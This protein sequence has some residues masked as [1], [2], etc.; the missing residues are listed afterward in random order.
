MDYKKIDTSD[1]KKID[2]SLTAW[3]ENGKPGSDALSLGVDLVEYVHGLAGRLG[4]ETDNGR[5]KLVE[6]FISAPPERAKLQSL[7]KI[8]SMPGHPLESAFDQLQGLIAAVRAVQAIRAAMRDEA[9]IHNHAI[10]A[11]EH[12]AK[13]LPILRDKPAVPPPPIELVRENTQ[14]F[15]RYY[16]TNAIQARNARYPLSTYLAVERLLTYMLDEPDPADAHEIERVTILYYNRG[17]RQGE[18]GKLQVCAHSGMAGCYL[19][20]VSLGL[21][22]VDQQMLESIEHAWEWTRPNQAVRIS[23]EVPPLVGL[24]DGGSAGGIITCAI[25]AAIDPGRIGLNSD[26]TSTVAVTA[27]NV[28]LAE[29]QPSIGH[30]SPNSIRPKLNAAVKAGIKRVV[31]WRGQCDHEGKLVESHEGLKITHAETIG[32]VYHQLTG[33]ARI[34]GVIEE[35]SKKRLGKWNAQL[36]NF[37]YV[38]PYYD[39]LANPALAAKAEDSSAHRETPGEAEKVKH[40][41]QYYRLAKESDGAETWLD[42]LLKL[43]NRICVTEDAGM[44]KSTFTCRLQAYLCS[45]AGQKFFGDK[46]CLAV[47]FEKGHWAWPEDFT[48]QYPEGA[49]VAGGRRHEAALPPPA[50]PRRTTLFREL[51]TALDDCFQNDSPPAREIVSW[52]VENGRLVLLLDALD[53]ATD[54]SIYQLAQ[55]LEKPGADNVLIVLTTRSR[56]IQADPWGLFEKPGWQFVRIEGFTARQQYRYLEGVRGLAASEDPDNDEKCVDALR[57]LFRNYEG[58][59]DLLRTPEVLKLVRTIDDGGRI[60]PFRTRCELY[61]QVDE[62]VLGLAGKKTLG[63][64]PTSTELQRWRKLLAAVAFEMMVRQRYSYTVQ[65]N[66]VVQVQLRAEERLRLRA[67]GSEADPGS[68]WDELLQVSD[69]TDHAILEDAQFQARPG[70]PQFF[71]FKHRGMMEYYCGLYLAKHATTKAPAATVSSVGVPLT[72][73]DDDQARRRYSADP[74]WY[75]PWLFAIEFACLDP[76]AAIGKHEDRALV[77]S[78]AHLFEPAERRDQPKR[79]QTDSGEKPNRRPTQL[80]YLAWEVLAPLDSVPSHVRELPPPARALENG[81]LV[82]D[83][84]HQQLCRIEKPE[85]KAIAR[86]LLASFRWC[87]KVRDPQNERYR[88][89]M[90]SPKEEDGHQSGEKQH[91]VLLSPFKM[92]ATA[93]TVAQFSLFDPQYATAEDSTFKKYASDSRCPAIMVDYYDAVQFCRWLGF[94]DLEDGKRGEFRLP[95]EAEWEFACRG[96][97]AK[98]TPFH[99][100]TTLPDDKANFGGSNGGT[101]RVGKYDSANDWDL[102]DMH[103]NVWE[104]C[105]DWYDPDYYNVSGG[106]KNPVGPPGPRSVRVMR[107]GC[108]FHFAVSCRSACRDRD[109]PDSRV[110][111]I[112]FR[113]ALVP[114]S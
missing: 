76:E 51:E 3:L 45:A 78:L 70:R 18:D 85:Q 81:F 28:A 29:A 96:G 15:G 94:G 7:F 68:Y 59:A 74:Q 110:S 36:E 53:Q 67:A 26:S 114:A 37:H 84:Y 47:R 24:L 19:D 102:H 66:E 2:T 100:G 87:P 46:P 61:A 98:P 17:S 10:N 105:Q 63:R 101:T 112:G 4:D 21:T 48:L 13:A 80:M 90:G 88:F 6:E 33:N 99:Y 56:M 72:L 113:V 73:L 25:K 11:I 49:T 50:D 55:S 34:E 97:A 23:P 27:P 43:G 54:E 1:Y 77:L 62:H 60:R 71:G 44:G 8:C 82:I 107:G 16:L 65:G 57:S 35:F 12:Y 5:K 32:D 93:V 31:L 22:R 104:W 30:V 91:D 108:W 69:C 83:E 92:Q 52:C 40:G 106:S 42:N 111:R 58:A 9:T 89:T 64:M 14:A 39:V 109:R 103:G 38:D 20:P 79:P 86:E 41:L 75:W 95:T